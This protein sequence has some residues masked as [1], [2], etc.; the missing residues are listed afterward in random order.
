MASNMARNKRLQHNSI[1]P[2]AA[3]WKQQPYCRYCIQLKVAD[4]NR[5][6]LSKLQ[7]AQFQ[8]TSSAF[9][10]PSSVAEVF[11]FVFCSRRDLKCTT[12]SQ[13][14]FIRERSP[15][16]DLINLH[17]QNKNV[18]LLMWITIVSNSDS[19]TLLREEKWEIVL[20]LNWLS[21]LGS[22]PLVNFTIIDRKEENEKESKKFKVFCFAQFATQH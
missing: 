6:F 17:F 12:S 13:G 16:G 5:A 3:S 21:L 22:V 4:F 1:W 14:F 8:S 18:S 19:A 10:L 9:F 15:S 7:L 2:L 20:F 11:I